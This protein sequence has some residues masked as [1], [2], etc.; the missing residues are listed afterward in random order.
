MVPNY[1]NTISV[2]D[3]DTFKEIRRIE[4]VS[5]LHHVRVDNRGQLWVSSRGDYYGQHPKLYCIDIN[6][7]SVVDSLDVVVGD[8]DLVGDSLY[9]LGTE[10]SYKTYNT[11]NN[12]CIVDVITHK[13]DN[14]LIKDGSDSKIKVPYGIKVN[15]DNGD[16]FV[17]DAKDYVNPG[18][19]YCYGKDGIM[20]WSVSTGDIPSHMVFLKVEL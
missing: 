11:S 19:L 17:T 16:I 13:V 15:E 1:E 20:K 8:F 18:K 2:I 5:N 10:F 7:E 12:Y 6:T 14:C 4:V 9:I 3:K